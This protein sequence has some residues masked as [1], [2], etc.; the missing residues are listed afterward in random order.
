M[1]G[2]SKPVSSSPPVPTG[3][4][5]RSSEEIRGLLLNAAREEFSNKSFAG[6]TTAAIAKRAKVAEIQMFR[7]FP[8]KAA[9]F[10][11]AIFAPLID[12]FRSFNAEH[13]SMAVDEESAREHAGL[14]IAELQAFLE[15][16]AKSLIS[17]YVAQTF[18]DASVQP[19][20]TGVEDLQAYFSESVARMSESSR[21]S[22][23]VDPELTVRVAFGTLLGCLTYSDWLFPDG[24]TKRGAIDKAI[25]EFILQGVGPLAGPAESGG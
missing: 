20:K 21:P 10:R 18:E 9:L 11:E 13:G 22:G 23:E 25:S 14:Y 1:A 2:I 12:H 4:R 8:S 19:T 24:A 3:R 15:E 5:R 17:L 7:Y 16:H 6:A